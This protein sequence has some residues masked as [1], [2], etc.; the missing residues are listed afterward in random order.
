RCTFVY[1]FE[2]RRCVFIV[3]ILR[4]LFSSFEHWRSVP[5]VKSLIPT[6]ACQLKWGLPNVCPV[7][8]LALVGHQQPCVQAFSRMVK[9]WKQGCTRRRW[10][11]GYERRSGYYTVYKQVYRMEHQTVY[12]CCP[13]WVQHDNE[14]GCLHLLCSAGT[15][16]NG[17]KCP[18][19]GSQMCQCPAGFQGPRCQYDVDECA[20]VNGG[21]QQD[22]V[23]TH[24]SFHCQCQV[25]Y[26][27]HTDGRTCIAINSCSVNKGGC[28][29]ECVQLSEDHYKCQ[30][31]SGYQL[32]RDGKSCEVIDPCTSGNEGCSQICQNER[33]IAKC[34]CHPGHYLSADKKCAEGRARCAHRCVNTL[35][36][37]TCV[38][39]P[40]F[41]LGAD[42]KQC[43]R[44]EM[45]IVDS[46][47]DS[48]GGCSHHCEHT[49]AGPR[50][51]C[52][53]GYRLDFDGKTCAESCCSQFCINYAGGYEC[54][55]KAG[56]QPNADGCACDDVDECRLDNGNCDHFCVNSLGSYECACKEGYRLGPDGTSV[57][58]ALG[59][60][61]MDV[62]EAAG[63]AG[64]PGLQFRGPPQL[65]RYTLGAFYEDEHPRGELTLVHRVVCL[66]NTFG[67]DC[68]LS[69]EDC[70]NGGRCN[71]EHSG[72]VCS[73][74]WTGIICN[75]TCSPGTYGR[76]C[77]STC[78]CQNGGSCDPI[79]GQCRCP[80]GVL[81]KLCEDGCPKG[82]FGKNCNKPCNC[83]NNGYCHRLYGACLCD[84]G[85]YGRFCH[86]TCPRWA[87]GA[88]CSEECQCVK[89][90]T[91][92]CDARN[93]TCTCK[94]GYHGKKCQ[95]ECS[96]GFYGAGCKLRCNCSTDVLCDRETGICKHPC[97][98]GFH[99][100]KCHLLCQP[101]SFGVNCEQRCSCGEAP[102][103]P[104][105][106]QCICP[107]GKTGA[108]CEQDCPAGWWGPDCQFSC[109]PCTN[110]GQCNR[111]TGACDC[112]PG[113]TGA[114]CSASCPDGYY[115]QNCLLLCSCSSS[116]QCHHITGECTCPPGWT[117][118]DCKHACDSGRWG[119]RCENMCVCNNSDGSCDPITGSCFCEPGFTGK[120]CEWRC[121]EGSFGPSCEYSCQCQNG[122]A[123]D[124]VSGACT[125]TA[126]WTGTFC[127]RACPDGFFGLDCHQ[128]CK[129]KNAAGCDHVLGTCRC[130]PGWLGE[131]C[132]Q[133]TYG[134]SPL[135][136]SHG[137]L[138][139]CGMTYQACQG[140]SY[141][142][143][144]SH[145]CECHNGA[146]CHHVTGTCLCRAGWKG[147]TSVHT[148]L[149]D[150]ELGWL[151]T[152]LPHALTR[153]GCSVAA[154]L[155][156]RYG[157]GCAHR[158][159]CPAGAPCHHLTG[160]C[161]CPPGFTGYGCEKSKF[162]LRM[163]ILP[164]GRRQQPHSSD[165]GQRLLVTHSHGLASFDLCSWC[166]LAG[167]VCPCKICSS[168]AGREQLGAK[169]HQNRPR[170]C[171]QSPAPARRHRCA[172]GKSAALLSVGIVP[173][174]ILFNKFELALCLSAIFTKT[175]LIYWFTFPL[176]QA[177]P[178]GTYGKNCN[179]VCQCSAE[180]EECHPVTGDCACRPGY[181]GARCNVRCPLGFYG[182]SCLQ[183]CA[184]KN[185]ASCDA[186]T[187]QCI[188]P[189]GYQG[190]YCEKGCDRG[191]FG[192]RCQHRCDCGG[193][194]CD[195]ETGKCLCPPGK[196]GDKCDTECRSDKYGPDC[197]LRCQ[198]ASKSQ[199]NPYNGNCLCPA[200][201]MGP[202]CKEGF[203][204]LPPAHTCQR[205][206]RSSI[207]ASMKSCPEAVGIHSI[208]EMNKEFY[209][210][211]VPSRSLTFCRGVRF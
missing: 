121:P 4:L 86:L 10:C 132:E 187:G 152:I 26:R 200:T 31:Q 62:E 173:A 126:G 141:G 165:D 159:R 198:C 37:F 39:N 20:V 89:E 30:C 175:N 12:K 3:S 6:L 22:C 107:A 111:E 183:A 210:L 164:L 55:C 117:G 63:F 23:N 8:E 130:L 151:C 137:R 66:D 100:E 195:P 171:Q 142:P 112:P 40:G 127:G 96:P 203:S 36:S 16:F 72:C 134:P 48:N 124:H 69:C 113:Y 82:L 84:P 170:R 77:A 29:Q 118:H 168:Q 153:M 5:V 56:F 114:S 71:S 83:A 211:C 189:L 157:T 27:L 179:R 105:T 97:P 156:G 136:C 144:C 158:C 90:H 110:G 104:K 202:T 25:G 34:R 167:G 70:L 19:A 1:C 190:V 43:Y 35:G 184:C 93:G 18:E 154:C 98:L 75:E 81:G 59:G 85:L 191:W 199:C 207:P 180:N 15:C 57:C 87:F 129:C 176:P 41:E 101:G 149:P 162:V 123:C 119:Q 106:G 7:F 161:S 133:R 53:D 58:P 65:L 11:M 181:Y 196:T 88:G 9:M 99:G 208:C 44:I 80:P 74:G 205:A 125:C 143:G 76:G 46:C 64:A 135:P 109:E 172:V 128:V 192:E 160:E 73:P 140:N 94:P 61:E 194:P 186:V 51:S 146:L 45:E 150:P 13:G 201:W 120:H 91:L 177:C 2:A 28:E 47:Q 78:K 14:P 49:T 33:G 50:C 122:A 32:K 103:D 79:M 131:T 163:Q 174:G 204:R 169:L 116:A 17:G 197:S 42:G 24:G 60:E 115:G 147:A 148:F 139:D 38:C 185:G 166:G 188:C 209:L 102:C 54:A 92:E 145:T 182:L 21:C 138:L 52:D 155:P 178:P 108:T 193:A 206:V 95:K 68:S 67:N